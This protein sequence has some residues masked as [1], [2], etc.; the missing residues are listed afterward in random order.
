MSALILGPPGVLPP[1]EWAVG[2]RVSM[3]NDDPIAGVIVHRDPADPADIAL[4]AFER[5]PKLL[6]G[7]L[8]ALSLDLTT[9]SL[10][11][12]TRAL[13]ALVAPD[14]EQPLTAP[15]WFY[16][17]SAVRWALLVADDVAWVFVRAEPDPRRALALALHAAAG[18]TP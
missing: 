11:H 3:Y 17:P 14:V 8:P 13:L 9:G 16:Y 6:F 2:A 12:G 15:G 1:G 18:V 10:D 7:H 4:H 5:H